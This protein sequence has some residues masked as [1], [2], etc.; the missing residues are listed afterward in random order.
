M[1]DGSSKAAIHLSRKQEQERAR[2]DYARLRKAEQEKTVRL[3][4]LRLAK[5]A[6]DR[7]TEDEAAAAKAAAKKPASKRRKA[8]AARL[9]ID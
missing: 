1:S 6:A 7:R 5:E 8:G 3:R 9:P 2:S 4:A